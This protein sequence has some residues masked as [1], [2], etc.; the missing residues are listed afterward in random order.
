MTEIKLTQSNN[1]PSELNE[2]G[3][4][5]CCVCWSFFL[6]NLKSVGESHIDLREKELMNES[7]INQ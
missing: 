7:F 1:K 6:T 4:I 3:F 5:N 2:F